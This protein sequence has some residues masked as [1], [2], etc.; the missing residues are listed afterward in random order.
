MTNIA[1]I[2]PAGVFGG[3]R[4]LVEHCNGLVRRGHKVTYLVNDQQPIGWLPCNFEQRPL[5]D[6]GGGY[7]VVVGSAIPTWPIAHDLARRLGAK[8]SA[9]M[10]MAEWLFFPSAQREA[11]MQAFAT[12]LD[13]VMVI[14]EWLAK[15]AEA[16]PGRRVVRIR[17]GIDTHLFYPQ[18]FPDLPAFDGV[19]IVTEGYGHNPAKDVDEMTLRAIRHIKYDMGLPVRMLGFSQFGQPSE[20]FDKFWQTP[21]QNVIRMI[22]SSA[23]I[24]LKASRYEGR[25]GPDIEAMA[26]GVAVCRAIG[27]GDDDL[28]DGHNCLKVQYGDQA[29]YLNNLLKLIREPDYRAW[30]AGNGLEYAKK[31]TWDGAIDAIEETLTGVV[32]QPREAQQSYQYDLAAYNDMQQVIVEW[33]TPQAMWLGETLAD[34]LHPKSVLDIGCGPGT[35]LVPFKPEARVLGVDGAPEAGKALE[36]G[37]FIRADFREDLQ[38]WGLFDLAMCI[39]VAEHLPPDRADF[40]V[41]LLTASADVVFFSAAQPGQGGTLHLNEQPREYWLE[42]FQDRGFDLHPRHGELARAIAANRHCQRVQW[43]IGNAMLLERKN[44]RQ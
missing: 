17:N 34:M 27:Q 35:Y 40:L 15:L 6:P 33:E 1:Y 3:V 28:V 41:K 5:A 22:Y 18:K 10:Q 21:P 8:S 38:T 31:Y 2:G 30:L 29:G 24:F 9:V 36:P 37:E 19:T 7:D 25:P 11:I 39:E 44:D 43:L 26:C 42:K 12:P 32:S 20:V 13:S 23:D 14:S 4:A 16:V